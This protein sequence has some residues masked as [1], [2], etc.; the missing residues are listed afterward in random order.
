M[1]NDAQLG[2]AY[3]GKLLAEYKCKSVNELIERPLLYRILDEKNYKRAI[4]FMSPDMRDEVKSIN[5][6]IEQTDCFEIQAKKFRERTAPVIGWLQDSERMALKEDGTLVELQKDYLPMAAKMDIRKWSNIIKV[7]LS[8]TVCIG[9]RE[10]GTVVATPPE[11]QEQVENW[12]DIK[13]FAVNDE[14]KVLG[15]QKDGTVVLGKSSKL[16][17]DKAITGF[18]DIVEIAMNNAVAVALSASGQVFC[19]QTD[20]L[21]VTYDKEIEEIEKWRDIAKLYPGNGYILGLRENGTVEAIKIKRN[22]LYRDRGQL[23]VQNWRDIVDISIS[24][25][26][27]VGLKVDGTVVAAGDNLLKECETENWEDIIAV[28]AGDKCTFGLKS[29]GEVVATAHF[30][31]KVHGIKL[32]D[33]LDSIEE[34]HRKRKSKADEMHLEQEK[35]EA[36]KREKAEEAKERQRRLQAERRSQGLCPYCGGKFKGLFTKKC[37]QCGKPKD[38]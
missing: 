5:H 1:N 18:S 2:K 37:S 35:Y 33:P 38:Y 29:N 31:E 21:G 20:Y 16:Y 30:N 11:V 34:C 24:S 7:Y 9:L 12:K 32:F 10:D 36:Y 8:R 13:S 26:H 4:E 27:T 23:N 19:Q 17:G 28:S 14:Y 22:L 15:L 25:S 3:L 6:A